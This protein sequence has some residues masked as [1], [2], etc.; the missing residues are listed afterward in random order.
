MSLLKTQ[1]VSTG[2]LMHIATLGNFNSNKFSYLLNTAADTEP[3]IERRDRATVTS[4]T[5]SYS[6]LWTDSPTRNFSVIKCKIPMCLV[7]EILLQIDDSHSLWCQGTSPRGCWDRYLGLEWLREK[8]RS[9]I[10]W[11][12]LY[13]GSEQR[14]SQKFAGRTHC[15]QLSI[16]AQN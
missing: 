7:L 12:T 10:R 8:E 11:G 16:E 4:E 13:K 15:V 14:N 1:P 6:V 2:M 3:S 9:P 5:A